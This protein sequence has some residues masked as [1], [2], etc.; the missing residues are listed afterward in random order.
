MP[1][2]TARHAPLSVSEGAH[3]SPGCPYLLL[4]SQSCAQPHPGPQ[5]S[6]CRGGRSHSAGQAGMG[7]VFAAGRDPHAWSGVV[8]C[9][10]CHDPSD[11]FLLTPDSPSSSLLGLAALLEPWPSL[12]GLPPLTLPAPPRRQPAPLSLASP[13]LLLSGY[14][15]N[16]SYLLSFPRGIGLTSVGPVQW[17][18]IGS[19]EADAR[20][21]RVGPH[22]VVEVYQSQ[23][24]WGQGS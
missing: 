11:C 4:P 21:V 8:L 7:V 22:G 19:N 17:A 3:T 5:P 20:E 24:P 6:P 16:H 1:G 18:G 10:A 2:L 23:C 15:W 14:F 9:L 12:L 13:W